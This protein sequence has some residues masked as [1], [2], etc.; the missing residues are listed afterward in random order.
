MVHKDDSVAQGQDLR[1]FRGNK[2]DGK[3]LL[4]QIV[5]QLI[6]LVLRADIDAV[7]RLVHEED[8]GL[9]HQP[10][11]D[12]GLL[13][14][15]AGEAGD[16]RVDGRGL[17]IQLLGVFLR[18]AQQ[19]LGVQNAALGHAALIDQQDIFTD[20]HLQE[21]ALDLSALGDH[22]DAALDGVITVFDVDFFTVDEDLAALAHVGAEDALQRLAAARADKARQAK[23]LAWIQVEG[24]VLDLAC[25]I[26]EVPDRE[27]RRF[28]GVIG[29][30][31]SF[32]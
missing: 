28:A 9:V 14:V 17:D 32:M 25:H 27:D 4:C 31:I 16:G 2:H 20:S 24:H 30:E 10:A 29:N 26:I 18:I 19:L 12:D 11:G 21:Q 1:H 6:D 3:P 7:G 15:A 13:L 23:D 22:A 8:G 5:D